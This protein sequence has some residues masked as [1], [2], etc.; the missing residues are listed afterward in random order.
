MTVLFRETATKDRRHEETA[1]AAATGSHQ[2]VA[3]TAGP[4]S[5]QC[6]ETDRAREA[7]TSARLPVAIAPLLAT[8]TEDRDQY[9]R[10]IPRTVCR[11]CNQSFSTWRI[12]K[13]LRPARQRE[14]L[15][16]LPL[17]LL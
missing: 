15:L 8:E 3:T 10:K 17:N 7:E 5:R 12:T 11:S 4:G 1:L 2:L 9:P 16:V 14:F 13:H 6:V